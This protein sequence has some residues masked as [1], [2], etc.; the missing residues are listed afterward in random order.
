M[1]SIETIVI[2]SSRRRGTS[3]ETIRRFF[4]G[5]VS[6]EKPPMICTVV[7]GYDARRAINMCVFGQPPTASFS[8]VG[9]DWLIGITDY[10]V[11]WTTVGLYNTFIF[12]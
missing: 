7:A 1:M 9:T 3:A 11:G 10:L 6:L 8:E 4:D 12:V 5:K 2:R